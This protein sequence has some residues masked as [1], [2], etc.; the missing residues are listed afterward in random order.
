MI[1]GAGRSAVGR[2]QSSGRS[3]ASSLILA[4]IIEAGNREL[5]TLRLSTTGRRLIKCMYYAPEGHGV[6]QTLNPF[7]RLMVWGVATDRSDGEI[8]T[9]DGGTER[10]RGV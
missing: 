8:T 7:D 9:L 1:H 5:R 10:L 3:C 4:M 2:P 6:G